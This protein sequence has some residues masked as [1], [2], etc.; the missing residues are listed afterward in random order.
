MGIIKETVKE[1]LVGKKAVIVSFKKKNYYETNGS[2]QEL[3]LLALTLRLKIFKTFIV[4][5][6]IINPA[7]Y[8][9]KGKLQELKEFGEQNDISL[10]IFEE[11][12][13][14]VQQRN[15]ENILNKEVIDRTGLILQIFAEHARSSE[16]KIQVELAQLNYLLPRLTGHGIFLSRLGGGL[17]T[18]GPGEMKLEVYRRRIKERIYHLNKKI[19]EI[20]KHRE[21]LRSSRERKNYFVVSLLGYTNVGK[22]TLLNSLSSK[23]DIYSADYLFSTLDPTSRAVYLGDGKYCLMIDTVGLLHKLPHHLI[24]AFKATLEE[25]IFSNLLICMYDISSLYIERQIETTYEVRKLLK[26]EEKPYIEVFNKVDLISLEEKEF[27]KK[28]FPNG[29]FISA[30][31][32]EGLQ[33][34]KDKIKRILYGNETS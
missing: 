14:P 23:K 16:G 12:L 26:I 8:I 17:G 4:K 30:S 32:G 33:I 31:T 18:R 6:D 5:A 21:V 2:V 25:A 10:F 19:Q 29:I 22:S 28:R 7:T 13:S 27:L 34:L 15:L 20:E 9:G 24:A 1:G 3:E 11:E